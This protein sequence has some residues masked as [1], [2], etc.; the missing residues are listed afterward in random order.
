MSVV[1]LPDQA[2][3]GYSMEKTNTAKVLQCGF[4]WPML[5]K[6]AHDYC[7]RCPRSQQLGRII[8]GDVMPL[9]SII[10]MEVFL[11]IGY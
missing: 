2:Y 9:N 3:G 10:I 7:K 1:L 4:H 8:R 11:C 6:D 5:F